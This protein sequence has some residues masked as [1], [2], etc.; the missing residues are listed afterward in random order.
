[1]FTVTRWLLALALPVVALA[2]SPN[3]TTAQNRERPATRPAILSFVLR[4]AGTVILDPFGSS[5]R[6]EVLQ[7]MAG[8]EPERGSFRRARLD[9]I[10]DGNWIEEGWY[11]IRGNVIQLYHHDGNGSATGSVEVGRY[12]E[13]IICFQDPDTGLPLAFEFLAPDPGTTQFADSSPTAAPTDSSSTSPTVTLDDADA[14]NGAETS[15]GKGNVDIEPDTTNR[16]APAD[17]RTT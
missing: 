4:H 7:L 8:P 12:L 14:A 6:R 11:E 9:R 17:E 13:E 15:D 2:S 5:G 16:C 3:D 1:M 10:G